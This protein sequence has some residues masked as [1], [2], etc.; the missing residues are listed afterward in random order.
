[1]WQ[2]LSNAYKC[3]ELCY[4][5]KASKGATIDLKGSLTSLVLLLLQCGGRPAH[6]WKRLCKAKPGRNPIRRY[7]KLPILSDPGLFGLLRFT[8]RYWSYII[9]HASIVLHSITSVIYSCTP[10]W[11]KLTVSHHKV[12]FMFLAH[13]DASGTSLMKFQLLKHNAQKGLWLRSVLTR[14]QVCGGQGSNNI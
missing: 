10:N 9:Q 4:N 7:R 6:F 12:R 8:P 3:A 13:A 11:S 14:I 5:Q 2:L 1:M